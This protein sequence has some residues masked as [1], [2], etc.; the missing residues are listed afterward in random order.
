MANNA[1]VSFKLD[2]L[3]ET[4]KK[5]AKSQHYTDRDKPLKPIGEELEKAREILINAYR[6]FAGAVKANQEITPA[7]E[8]IIDN[9][10]IIQEQ[11]VQI[12]SDFPENYQRS[13]PRLVKGPL[14]GYPRIYELIQNIVLYNDNVIDVSTLTEAVHAFQEETTLKIGE[15]WAIPILVRFSLI[16][17]LAEKAEVVLKRRRIRPK[18]TEL[19]NELIEIEDPEPGEIIGKITSWLGSKPKEKPEP[20]ILTELVNQLQSSGILTGEE[21]RWFEYRFRKF[22][23]QTEEA[24]RIEAQ[25][26]SRHQVSIQ[27]AVVSLRDVSI[28]DW[29]DF[30]EECSLVE[31]MLRLDPAGIYP[32][33]DFETRDHYRGV[34]ERI[35]RGTNLSETEIAE[36]ILIRA[37]KA[38]GNTQNDFSKLFYDYSVLKTHVG[39]YILG[40]GY[41]DFCRSLNYRFPVTEKI[42]K[43]LENYPGF[44]IY[45]VGFLTLIFL[46]I[47]WVLTGAISGNIFVS[48]A[49][50]LVSFFPAMDLSVSVANRFFAWFLPPR[51]LPKMDYKDGI[52]N[53]ARTL[54]VVPTMLSSP[55]NVRK[56]VE[57]L[58]IKA[59]SNSDP[60]LQFVLLSDFTDSKSKS[61]ESDSEILNEAVKLIAELNQKYDSK[62]GDKFFLLHRKRLWNEKEEIWM[63][64]ER[65]RG[66]LE[67]LNRLLCNPSSKTTFSVIEGDFLSSVG[68]SPVRYVITL[69]ADTKLPPAIAKELVGTI[70]HPLNRA[71][72]NPELKRVTKGYGIIQPR[73]SI[74]PESAQKTNFSK[75]FSGNVGMDPYSTAVSD[76]YQDLNGEAVFTGKGIYDVRAF[77]EVLGDMFPDN[78]ILSHDLIESTYLR[79]GLASD[80]ELY[81]DYPSAYSGYCKRNHRWARGD[82]QI[83]SWI[84]G[85]IDVKGGTRDNPISLLSKWKI[86]DNLRR[87]LSPFFLILFLVS[88]WF[89]LPGRPYLWTLAALGILAFPIYVVLTTDLVNR[90]ARVRW[91]LYF[92]KIR[93]NLKINTLQ[94][95]TTLIV[96]PHQAMILLDAAVR[97]LWRLSV[98]KKNLLEWVTASQ[99]EHTSDNS[100]KTNTL[101]LL[102][103]VIFGLIIIIASILISPSYLWITIPFSFL[104]IVSP[105]YIYEANKP[106][107][108][109]KGAFSE[110]EKRKLR[111]Y[112][113]RTWFY[114]ERH[115]NEDHSWLPPDNYQERPFVPVANRT[116]PTNIGLGLTSVVTAYNMG[117]LTFG[118]MLNR[119]ENT[120]N[121][122][123]VLEKYRGHFFNWYD[124]T[125]GEV[126]HPRYISTVDSGNLAAG[127][128][129]VKEALKDGWH[130]PGFNKLIWNGLEDTVTVVK[131][132]FQEHFENELISEKV[133]NEV[134]FYADRLINKIKKKCPQEISECMKKLESIQDDAK[135]LS[136]ID[137]LPDRHS[138]GDEK[139]ENLLFWMD[140][141]L[142]MIESFKAE[143][144]IFLS[145]EKMI[146]TGYQSVENIYQQLKENG[147]KSS[148]FRKIQMWERQKDSVIK[149]CERIVQNMDFTFLYLSNRKLFS[150]G[151]HAEKAELDAGTYD[152][153]ASEARIASYIAVSKGDVPVEHWFRLGRRLTSLDENEILLSWGGTM[154]EYLMPTLFMKSYPETLLHHTYNQVVTWQKVY[155]SRRNLPWGQSESAYYFLNMDKHYQYRAFGAPGLGLKR[156]LAEDYVVAPYASF[157]ALMIEP[158]KS[159][160]NL[161][162]I[163]KLGGIGIFGFY[164][165]IDFS[166]FRLRG[167]D[168]YNVVQT[169]M[170]HHHGMSLLAI[171]NVLNGW[172]I[173]KYFHSDRHIMG[174]DLLLQERV[175]RGIPVKE[176][177]PIEVELEPGEQQKVHRVVEHAGI[178]DLDSSPPRLHLLTNGRYSIYVTHAGTGSSSYK[179]LLLTGW[180]PDPTMDSKGLFFYIRDKETG[181][182]WSA[183]HQ[184][185]KRKPDRYDTWFHNG[186]IVTSRVDDWIETTMEVTV[187]SEKNVELRRLTLTNYSER[188]RSIEVT[189]YAEIVLNGLMDHVSHPAFSK[190]FIQTEYLPEN[191]AIIAKRRPRSEDE[192]THWIVHAVTSRKP[193]NLA[194][195]LEFETE[196]ANFIG[197]GFS[198][199]KPAAMQNS[200]ELSGSAGNVSDPILSLR[201]T[202]QLNPGEKKQMTFS[203]GWAASREEAVQLADLYDNPKAAER[204]F[205]MS[206]VYSDIELEHLGITPKQ[207]HYFQKLASYLVYHDSKYRAGKDILVKNRRKQSGL[208]AYGISGDMPLIVFRI[209]Q[210][211]QLKSVR[212]LLKAHSFWRHKGLEAELLFLNDHPPSY[213]DELQES[214]NQMIESSLE[215]HI[216]HKKGGVFAHQSEKITEEDKVLILS[217]ASVVFEYKLPPEFFVSGREKTNSFSQNTEGP[218]YEPYKPEEAVESESESESSENLKFFNGFGGFSSDGKEYHIRIKRNSKNRLIELPPAPWVNVVSNETFGFIA[219]EKG[220]GYTWS[221]NSR[222]NKLTTWSNDP[223]TDP[224]SEAIYIRDEDSKKFWSPTPGPVPGEGD[225]RVIHGHGYTQY[226]SASAEIKQKLTQFVPVDESVKIS[227]LTLWNKSSDQRKLSVFSYLEWVLGVERIQSARHLIPGLSENGDCLYTVNYYNNEFAGRVAFSFIS[228]DQKDTEI[229]YTTDR[230]YFIGR[231]RSPENPAALRNSDNLNNQLVFG[232]DICAAHQAHFVIE[233]GEKAEV[234]LLTGEAATKDKADQIVSRY[235][236]YETV[237]D[238]YHQAKESWSA[239]LS[240]IQVQTPDESLNVMMNGW[241]MYQNLA[242]RMMARTAFY[243]SGGAYGFRDQ[244]QDAMA[245]LYVDSELTRKQLLLH[246]ERQ[247]PEGDVQHWWHPPTGR[248]VRTRIT[249]D[250]LWLPYVTSFYISSTGD[251][252]VLKE[253]IPFIKAR[254]LEEDEHEVY[255][256]PEKSDETA[257]LYEH[258]R[259][260][261]DHSLRFGEHGIPLMGGGDWNDGMNRVGEEG[262]GESVWLG[263]FLYS[264]LTGFGKICRIMNDH[265]TEK[266]C[267]LQASELKKNLNKNGWDGEW[268]LRAFYDDGTPLGSS[269]NEE[270]R[271]DGISQAWSV[272]SG[273]AS[274][275]RAEKSL[276]AAE[277]YLISNQDKIIRLLT[278]PFDRTEKNPGYIKGYIPGVRENGGQ[279]THGALWV[280]KAMAEAGKGSK[281]SD[282]LHMINPVNHSSDRDK[283]FTYKSEPYVVAA[284]IYGEHPL[285]G[286]GG[287]TWYTGSGGWMYRVALESILGFTFAD[288][289]AELKPVISSDWEQYEITYTPDNETK[290][291]IVVNNP[292]HLEKGKLKVIESTDDCKIY[293]KSVFIEISNDGE[294]HRICIEIQ[295][296]GGS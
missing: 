150:I 290:Y 80:I 133:Y 35:S 161:E 267:K 93:S 252:S 125:L 99:V 153:L 209:N 185:V 288:G 208:W 191:H 61:A 255:L 72:Y 261:I 104:W 79:A 90:P 205:N 269:G 5:I 281:A 38:G 180:N 272:I 87:S 184:P 33:M 266:R 166:P 29:S 193:D 108:E 144:E 218:K 113:R 216:F 160:K 117:Y 124:T 137:L 112:A 14:K 12:K 20:F 19:V 15:I 92:E 190:L 8:W 111:C 78:R 157:L 17:Q 171:E 181:S 224:H 287:W 227:V 88:G 186:K 91:K 212:T 239:K 155:A 140:S 188:K 238:A 27:N 85:K 74:T 260:A 48:L 53:R 283:V 256:E 30:V 152:L 24:L 146:Y 76:I 154:F 32:D 54:V 244:L 119:L 73:I 39:Y 215:A 122:L 280:I 230:K 21:K 51:I 237:K 100:F 257:S 16:E 276:D 114:F 175:P 11:F 68:N 282:Y 106:V 44:Y 1:Q 28:T 275:T 101:L 135:K 225:Y 234:I 258:C 247:F 204:E 118:Q 176:P 183:G 83:A 222:E 65:K 279:Y 210:P 75:I 97:T 7:A 132:I 169:Y 52:P 58:E 37:D 96:L 231:N 211:E 233:A 203:I 67:E 77:H 84:S 235:G 116:S 63:G 115:M 23:L 143:M 296:A 263:F 174:C 273:V 2:E 43:K 207:A 202:I 170:A 149:I 10:Y 50:L 60:S 229:Y 270:C 189:S 66:K 18:I 245:A 40:E 236:N 292:R 274:K 192:E 56:Q 242:C 25:T 164:D 219:T 105:Y 295:Q 264:V 246:A 214:I 177:H 49:V 131:E 151:Y 4:A 127:L 31:K 46:G 9:Y 223:V 158:V 254:Q 57:A 249:D 259:R 128:I 228:A 163:E 268:Y 196:R 226:H 178:D 82:W 278:P 123:Q 162:R 195:P 142:I 221:V 206:A 94:F 265:E 277:H 134:N 217:V 26:Q 197:R 107:K 103:N 120:L 173:Q 167:T 86:F 129:V 232:D 198:L 271:I 250:L 213:S 47:L 179:H 165:A 200:V 241:L 109:E 194:S 110:S 284:D 293:N 6:E 291:I 81:D 147:K 36:E 148:G 262:K 289:K 130:T 3:K 98:S 294:E 251:E 248:G 55:E 253:E 102:P 70:S 199:E 285:T 62:Y 201:K 121:S 42:R 95:L 145:A 172:K 240:R 126:L 138:L 168:S 45:S 71:W 156:G 59:L 69:D 22:G 139:M 243:Q 141:P 136:A 286:R 64:W 182:Y 13:I 34:I 220:S 89:W 159:V 41:D 187:S